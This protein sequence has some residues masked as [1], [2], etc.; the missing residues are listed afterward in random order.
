M[1]ILVV[2]KKNHIHWP[3]Y[4]ARGFEQG[5]HNVSL[6]YYNEYTLLDRFHQLLLN[7][8][9]DTHRFESELKKRKPTLVFFVSAFFIPLEFYKIAKQH[10]TATIGWVGDVFNEDKL[11]YKNFIDKLYVFDS[12]LIPLSND[13]GFN[14]VALLQVGYDPFIHKNK[15]LLRNKSINFIG[16]FSREREDILKQLHKYNLELYGIKWNKMQSTPKHWKVQN[17]KI[18]PIALAHIYNTTLSSLNIKQPQNV[19]DGVNMRIFETLGCGSCMITDYVK[20]I[21]LC[22]EPNKEILVYR[23]TEELLDIL[24]KIQYDHSFL[25]EIVNNGQNRI[26]TSPYTYKARLDYAIKDL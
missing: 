7:K 9:N 18:N 12:S 2:G 5:G 21:E 15:N 1:N 10:N 11:V 16:S 22:F 25:Q 26:R 6:F 4:V 23:S 20:D 17:K 24:E 19:S 3:L 14:N 13:M 8:N